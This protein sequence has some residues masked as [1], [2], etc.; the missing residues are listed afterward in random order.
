MLRRLL[1]VGMMVLPVASMAGEEKNPALAALDSLWTGGERDSAMTGLMQAIDVARADTDTVTLISFLSRAGAWHKDLGTPADGEIL[2]RQALDLAAATGDSAL[3]CKPRR[4]LGA[5]LTSQ[6]RN[7]EA[8]AQYQRSEKLAAAV[9]NLEYEGWAN[10]GL[11]WDAGLK[12]NSQASLG[13]YQRAVQLFHE[14]GDDE[15]ELWATLGTANARFYLSEY[16]AA[17]AAFAEVVEV[18]ERAGFA[19]HEAIALNNTA[20]LRFALGRPDLSLKYYERALAL[21]DSIG[22]DWERVPPA[23]NL[24]SC[25]AL[26]GKEDEAREIFQTQLEHCRASQYRDFEARAL[27]K[28]A[29]LD[30]GAG[31]SARA[32]ESYQKILSIGED[33]PVV[34]RVEATLGLAKIFSGNEQWDAAREVLLACDQHISDDRKSMR[35]ARLDLGLARLSLETGNPD[36]ARVY[37]QHV[38]LILGPAR[39]RHGLELENLWAEY[40]FAKGRR[41]SARAHL[42]SATIIWNEERGLP[43][44]PQWREERGSVG[45]TIY[46]RL[47][48]E[49]AATEGEEKAFEKLQLFKARVLRERRWGPGRKAE[50]AVSDTLPEFSLKEFRKNALRDGEIFLDSYVGRGQ[51]LVF[52]VTAEHCILLKL[53]GEEELKTSFSKLNALASQ[54]GSDQKSLSESVAE[55]SSLLLGELTEELAHT[56]KVIFSPDGIFNMIP[57]SLLPAAGSEI[58]FSRVPSATILADLRNSGASRP[59]LDKPRTLAVGGVVDPEAVDLPGAYRELEKLDSRYAGITVVRPNKG[60]DAPELDKLNGFDLIHVAAHSIGDDRNAWQSAIVL[61]PD[62]PA[63]MIRAADLNGVR[64][65]SR[66]VVLASCSSATGRVLSG[67]GVQGLTAA[68]LAAG[69]PSV[70]ASLWPV[71][72]DA[73]GF[74]MAAFYESLASGRDAAGALAFAREQCQSDPLFNLPFHWGAFILVGEPQVQIP[75]EIK[76]TLNWYSL[77]SIMAGVGVGLFIILRKRR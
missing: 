67:E 12:R 7:E 52:A 69:V 41:D 45:R 77:I 56:P 13:Y 76:G 36:G 4:W 8:L 26:L 63:M 37:L 70:V 64:L 18:A 29:K 23:L 34:E 65:D 25:L 75:L 61:D 59:P 14:F 27:L 57:T 38:D 30:E 33:L 73:T 44:D 24:G 47:A 15:A 3:A 49:I 53:P 2:V 6:G 42:E 22:Q 46:C 51:C 31:D 48:E 68:F 19:K 35:R 62:D 20:G 66:L 17:G 5:L 11:G 10:I 9:G 32:G 71:D 40:W 55:V 54:A 16:E 43:L 74:F 21:W 50:E 28:L 72:D 60:S 39:A 58:S 1:L